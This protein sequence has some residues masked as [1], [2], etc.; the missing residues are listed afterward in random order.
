MQFT[1]EAIN[2]FIEIYERNFDERISRED[3]VLMARR[4]VNMYR[5]FLRPLPPDVHADELMEVTL[6]D[7][8]PEAS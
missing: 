8:E 6:H 7:C 3:A 1:E 4:L 2:E 5:L